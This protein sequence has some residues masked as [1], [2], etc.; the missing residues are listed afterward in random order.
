M[1]YTYDYPRPAVTVD[2][3]IIK[4]DSIPE[5]L[6][7]KRKFEPYKDSWAMPG[8][9]IDEDETLEQAA[10]RELFEETSLKNIELSQYH[11]F[12]NP[13]RDPRGRTISTIFFGFPDNKAQAKANDDAKEVK[14]FSIYELPKLAFDHH[15]IITGFIKT[16]L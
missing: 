4:N 8:G 2:C 5:I 1:A 15:E 16:I 12:S 3:I 9:F 13:N 10:S 11:T 14:W 6:L 7:I